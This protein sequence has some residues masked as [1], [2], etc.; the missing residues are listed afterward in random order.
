M[1]PELIRASVVVRYKIK[2][3]IKTKLMKTIYKLAI[4]ELQ[5]PLLF[6]CGLV[7]S[8]YIHVSGKHDVY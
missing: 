1:I 6:A 2:L 3:L 4:A 7:D 5:S 8:D